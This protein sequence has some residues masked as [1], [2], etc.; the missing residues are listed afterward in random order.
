LTARSRL[1]VVFAMAFPDDFGCSLFN[2]DYV[3]LLEEV[4][5]HWPT[6]NRTFSGQ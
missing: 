6:S 3:Y 1:L 4:S 5:I 2:V